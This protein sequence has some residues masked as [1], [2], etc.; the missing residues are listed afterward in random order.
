[1]LILYFLKHSI[2]VFTNLILNYKIF[3][4]LNWIENACFRGVISQF[5]EKAEFIVFAIIQ[6]LYTINGM[7]IN[8]LCSCIETAILLQTSFNYMYMY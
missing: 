1:M 8:T 3:I 6:Q 4:S 2:T 7:R 5:Y